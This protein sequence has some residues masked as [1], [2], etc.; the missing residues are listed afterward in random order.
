MKPCES[1]KAACH[2]LEPRD[3]DGDHVCK[4]EGSWDN[5]GDTVTLPDLCDDG[6]R[7]SDNPLLDRAL[8]GGDYE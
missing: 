8:G 3:H 7:I 1:T 4:C 2:C 5:D 6:T